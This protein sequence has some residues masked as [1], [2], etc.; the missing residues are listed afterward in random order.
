ME[1]TIKASILVE[2]KDNLDITWEDEITNR[3][4]ERFIDR[5]EAYLKELSGTSLDFSVNIKA[6]DL[7]LER[8]RYLY[9]NVSDEFEKNFE[10]E[11]GRF[12]LSEAVQK[13]SESSE[14]T[15]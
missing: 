15:S 13:A 3:K 6:R 4:L 12:I 14:T 7:L 1:Q 5:S 9:N 2:L 10:A 11:L 8:C